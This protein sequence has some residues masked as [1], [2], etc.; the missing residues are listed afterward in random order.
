MMRYAMHGTFWV[1]VYLLFILAPLFA[2]LLGTWPARRD[3]W[4]EV[5]VALGYAGLAM[6]GLQFGLTA[7]FRYVTDPWGEDV[8]YHFHRQ[9]SLIAVGL[10]IAHPLILFVVRPELLALLNS[11]TAPWRA[12][13]A[14]L[15]TYSLIALVVTALWRAQL[16]IRYE[17]WHLSHIVLAVLAVAAGLLHMVGW[18]FYLT[19]PWK[20]VLWIGLTIFWIGLLVYV[21]IVKPLFMLRRPYRVSDVREERGDTWTLVMRPDGHPG[22]RF[23]PGQFGWL[24]VWGSPFTITGHP[25]SFSSSAAVA[26]GRVEMTIRNLGDFTSAVD[27]VPAG[28]RVYIDGPYG[29]FTI[30]NPADMHVLIAGGV[31]ITPM[32]SMIRT[33]ADRGDPRPV[34]LLYGS[35]DWESIT[36]REELEALKARLNLTVV[37]VLVHPP[38]DWTG[39]QGF[40]NSSTFLVVWLTS[41]TFRGGVT[42]PGPL[43]PRFAF[44]G[45]SAIFL[46]AHDLL[47]LAQPS[48]DFTSGW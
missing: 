2:L 30:G 21:R 44:H 31:G 19:D 45:R 23:S 47:V 26:D 36:F 20:Q 1:I 34:I 37:H 33:L 35:K 12:R 17:A 11:I 10:V 24:T 16:N 9:I 3:F 13:F 14:A 32:T 5:S 48:T 4:T 42:T 40:I 29:A 22:F 41:A 38:T 43:A 39:E 28:Q 25:F 15:S 27:K 8:I 6:M 46:A 7:R 18:S